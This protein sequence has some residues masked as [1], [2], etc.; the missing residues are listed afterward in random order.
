VR[1]VSW[2]YYELAETVIG[3]LSSVGSLDG[4]VVLV[5]LV[6]AGCDCVARH[7]LVLRRLRHFVGMELFG[8]AVV[9]LNNFLFYSLGKLADER[10]LVVGS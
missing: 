3:L 7:V 2:G 9:G 5:D 4:S 8:Y 1:L 6:V 10:W